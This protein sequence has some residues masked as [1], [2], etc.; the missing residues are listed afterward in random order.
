M[1]ET[2]AH[3]HLARSLGRPFRVA[4]YHPSRERDK[5]VLYDGEISIVETA[6]KVVS[7]GI[8]RISWPHF[9][10]K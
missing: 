8:L 7:P 10:P 3:H 9:A 5:K 4:L 6:R 1:N 2:S